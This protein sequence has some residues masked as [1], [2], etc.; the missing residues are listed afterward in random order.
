MKTALFAGSFDPITLGHIDVIDKASKVFDKLYIGIAKNPKKQYFFYEKQRIE[1]ITKS[2]K[3]KNINIVVIEGFVVD[4]CSEN[5]VDCLVRSFRNSIDIDY[6]QQLALANNY[7][8]PNITTMYIQPNPVLNHVSSS[9]VRELL[10]ANRSIKGLVH[11]NILD[12][13]KV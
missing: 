11:N 6:E 8:N 4:W 3:Q 7:L 5:K 13:C 12:I 10:R 9:F 1:M 2:I